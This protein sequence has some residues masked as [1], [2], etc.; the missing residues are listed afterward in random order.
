M[1]GIFVTGTD[2]NIG[3]TSVSAALFHRYRHAADLCYWKPIQTGFP[4]D[5]DTATVRILGICAEKEIYDNGIRMP[6][7]LSPH[8]SA[9]YEGTRI[10]FESLLRFRP[11]ENSHAWIV[12]GA[13]GVFVPI[14]QYQFMMDLIVALALPVLVIAGSQLGT[15]NHTLLTVGALRSRHIPVLGAVLVGTPNGDNR[16]SIEMYGNVPVLG[17]MPRFLQLTP[18]SIAVW[19]HSQLDPEGLLASALS[20]SQ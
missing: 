4:D 18:E 14:S 7:P 19:A 10:D 2:T 15:I 3:K 11:E 20:R 13:G 16:R 5:H 17:E 9:Q 1:K 12:E 8:L 6:R